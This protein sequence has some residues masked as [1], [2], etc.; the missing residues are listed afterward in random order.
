MQIVHMPSGQSVSEKQQNLPCT[1]LAHH[2]ML[3][4]DTFMTDVGMLVAI[5]CGHKQACVAPH[6]TACF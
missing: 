3:N 1:C 4:I 2:D 6:E 5:T